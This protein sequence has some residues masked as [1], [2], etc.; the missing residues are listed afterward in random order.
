MTQG[1]DKIVRYLTNPNHVISDP[2]RKGDNIQES[3][4]SADGQQ[5]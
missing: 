1:L 5:Q 3:Q 4:S 2:F